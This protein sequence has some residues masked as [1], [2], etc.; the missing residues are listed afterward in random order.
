VWIVHVYAAI[1]VPGTIRGM[2]RGDVTGK[3]KDPTEI[4]AE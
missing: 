2:P 3:P 1:R 4:P